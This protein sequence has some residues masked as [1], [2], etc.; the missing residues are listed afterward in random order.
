MDDRELIPAFSSVLEGKGIRCT[1]AKLEALIRLIKPRI[2]FIQEIWDQA[3]F[4]FTPPTSYDP[5]VVKK[6]WKEDI[7]EKMNMVTEVIKNCEPFTAES[8]ETVVK[9]L[10]TEQ[11]WSM[12][13]IM[14]AWRLLL[15]GAATGPGLFDLAEF[16]GKTEVIRRMKNGIEN[17]KA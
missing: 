16:L 13:A 4:F 17:I 7:A 3:W 10:I 1:E 15:V 8:I 9:S 11:E 14:N 12:G 6:R 5:S 2:N